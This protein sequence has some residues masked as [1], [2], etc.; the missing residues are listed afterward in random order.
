ML[1]ICKHFNEIGNLHPF[2]NNCFKGVNLLKTSNLNKF[3]HQMQKRKMS[4][5]AREYRRDKWWV[6]R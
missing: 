3:Q 4:G 6:T 5:C 1:E 2:M